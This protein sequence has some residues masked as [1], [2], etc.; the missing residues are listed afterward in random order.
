MAGE[1]MLSFVDLGKSAM[2]R[3]PKLLPWIQSWCPDSSVQPL[4]PEDWYEH[5]RNVWFPDHTPAGQTHLWAPS[6]AAPEELLKARHSS[7]LLLFLAC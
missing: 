2:D 6:P 1:D 5:K 7:T 3:C 4:T